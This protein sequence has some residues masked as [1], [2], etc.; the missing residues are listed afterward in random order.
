MSIFEEKK[1]KTILDNFTSK[2]A[3]ITGL[4][5][6]ILL[7]GTAEFLLLGGALL[8]SG[9]LKLGELSFG[10]AKTP[11]AAEGADGNNNAAPTAQPSNQPSGQIPPVTNRDHIR[12]SANASLTLIEYSDYEC[13][14]CKS[15]QP[16]LAR[17]LQEYEGRVK[18]VY[19]HFPLSFHE[20]A[21]KEAEAA[22]CVAELAGNDGF[23]KFNDTIYERT[24]SNGTGFALDD[25]PGLAEESGANKTAFQ[26]CLDS[27][28]Y[29]SYIEESM[30][31]GIAAGVDGTPATIILNEKGES[32]IVSGAQP[33]NNLKSAVDSML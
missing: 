11:T 22:E 20:N 6:G 18:L 21:Q 7:F 13:P 32:Q 8:K 14:F 17:L 5:G 28:K 4:V 2:Q 1:E 3:F 27:G 29:A 15:F 9:S 30:S 31:G 12:G 33:Y 26:Q 19:R 24:T 10:R 23:W 16:T 25:L